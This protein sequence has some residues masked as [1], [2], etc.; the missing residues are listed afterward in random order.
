MLG[1]RGGGSCDGIK[2]RPHSFLHADGAL[3]LM[4]LAARRTNPHPSR[5]S[6]LEA[7]LINWAIPILEV[8][9]RIQHIPDACQ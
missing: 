8:A 4:L 6:I 9:A 2:S 3:A 7:Y 5:R 1:G